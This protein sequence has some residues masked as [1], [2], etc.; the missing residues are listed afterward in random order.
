MK[1]IVDIPE[2]GFNACK[3]WVEM[4][5]ATWQDEFIA[6]GTPYNP[7]GDLIS[8]EALKEALQNEIGEHAL[9]VAI[10]RVIDNAPTVKYPFYQEAYQTGYEEGKAEVKK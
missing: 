5:T 1:L 6:K 9:S 2:E 7:S 8:R 3:A 10:D 4:G